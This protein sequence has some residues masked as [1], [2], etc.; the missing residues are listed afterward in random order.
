VWFREEKQILRYLKQI[1][2]S[3]H[4]HLNLDLGQDYVS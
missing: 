2:D 3:N 1:L 4:F